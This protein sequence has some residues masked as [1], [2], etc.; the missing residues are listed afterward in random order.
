METNEVTNHVAFYQVYTMGCCE[1][2]QLGRVARY[3]TDRKGQRHA[4]AASKLAR[5]MLGSALVN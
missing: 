1:Q 2:G 4:N 3:F 5:L